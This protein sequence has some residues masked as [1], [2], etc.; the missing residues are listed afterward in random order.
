[1][2]WPVE[3]ETRSKR[4]ATQVL[5][6]QPIETGHRLF[7]SGFSLTPLELAFCC[8]RGCSAQRRQAWSALSHQP[9]CAALRAEWPWLEPPASRAKGSSCFWIPAVTRQLMGLLDWKTKWSEG[10]SQ[11]ANGR[12]RVEVYRIGARDGH[13]PEGPTQWRLHPRSQGSSQFSWATSLPNR[14]DPPLRRVSGCGRTEPQGGQFAYPALPTV[15]IA[16]RPGQIHEIF[17]LGDPSKGFAAK[18]SEGTGD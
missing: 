15:A 5:P 18:Q 6:R 1:V 2:P 10:Q 3:R 8:T 17:L 4:P 14:L 13:S 11:P 12:S 7:R 16:G 9:R